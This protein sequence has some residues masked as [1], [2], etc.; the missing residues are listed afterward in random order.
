MGTDN[1][2][3][4]CTDTDDGILTRAIHRDV[5]VWNDVTFAS[6]DELAQYATRKLATKFPLKFVW[7]TARS[8]T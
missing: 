7:E 4:I 3:L 2:I 1:L 8:T 5:T 6:R